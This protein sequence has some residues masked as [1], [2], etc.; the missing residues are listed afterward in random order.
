MPTAIKKRVCFRKPS[1]GFK[2]QEIKRLKIPNC[3]YQ[4]CGRHTEAEP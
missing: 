3:K 2:D 1:Q 4:S